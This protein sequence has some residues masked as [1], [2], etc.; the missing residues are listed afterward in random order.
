MDGL[1]TRLQVGGNAGY[2]PAFAVEPHDG[3][4][5][6]GCVSDLFIGREAS[7]SRERH[8]LLGQDPLDGVRA[9]APPEPN[10]AD[11]SQLVRAQRSMLRFEL[12]DGVA[13]VWRQYAGISDRLLRKEPCHAEH[14][15]AVRLAVD[16]AHRSAGFLGALGRSP[17]EQHDWA[18][19]LVAGLLRPG[20]PEAELLP[21]LSGLHPAALVARHDRPRLAPRASSVPSGASA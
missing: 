9:G 21:V 15:E 6:L 20:E 2:V 13:D 8:G 17:A 18:D 7:R 11:G 3:E 14:V 19:Q 4:S 10:E 1:A 16:R 12:E 5:A